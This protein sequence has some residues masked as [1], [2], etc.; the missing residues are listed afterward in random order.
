ML[1]LNVVLLGQTLGTFRGVLVVKV[2]E[3]NVAS[4]LGVGSGHG[5]TN[6]GTGTSDDGS[7]ALEGETLQDGTAIDPTLVIVDEVSTV[8][9]V[10]GLVN[11]SVFGHDDGVFVSWC[12]GGELSG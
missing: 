10:K 11:N 3:S 6:T 12:F 1:T 4:H 7:L 2:P 9:R 8:E 5:V